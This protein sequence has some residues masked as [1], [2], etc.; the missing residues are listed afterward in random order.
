ML[1]CTY[2]LLVRCLSV[3]CAYVRACLSVCERAYMSDCVPYVRACVRACLSVFASVCACLPA[4]MS[5]CLS[6]CPDFAIQC[7]NSE[8]RTKN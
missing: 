2:V 4:S 6:V 8:V 1:V 7:N 5:V 3:P